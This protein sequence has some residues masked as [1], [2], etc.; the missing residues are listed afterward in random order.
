MRSIFAALCISLA[1]AGCASPPVNRDSTIPLKTVE[2]VD[3]NR[4]TGLWYEIARFPNS[5]QQDC[6]A[7]TAQYA[8]REDGLISVVNT[9]GAGDPRSAKGRARVVDE[10][11]N[12]KLEVS[13]FG[14]FW[15]DYWIIDLDDAYTLSLVGEPEGRYL[16]ILSR[17]PQLSDERLGAALQRLRTYGYD[18]DALYFTD[19]SANLD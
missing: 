7:V 16:W 4:Y 14:P 1:L 13:F 19:Q 12:S 15:G 18:T 17:S 3:L 2:A 11:T 8:L 9:C 5:F 6:D 10:E